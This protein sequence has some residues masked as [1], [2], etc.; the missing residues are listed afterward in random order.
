[1]TR[2]MYC[3]CSPRQH[4]S[5]RSELHWHMMNQTICAIN[6]LCVGHTHLLD[7]W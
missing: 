5:A 3:V 1:M 7:Y 4:M 6:C 2:L